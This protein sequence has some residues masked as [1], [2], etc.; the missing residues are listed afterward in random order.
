MI[1]FV[2]VVDLIASTLLIRF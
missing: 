1:S 2:V